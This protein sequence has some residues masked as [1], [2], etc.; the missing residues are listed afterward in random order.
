MSRLVTFLPFVCLA[1]AAVAQTIT[2]APAGFETA[3]GTTSVLYPFSGTL[4]PAGS[5]RYQEVHTSLRTTPL[6]NIVA[7]NFRRDEGTTTTT[8]AVARTANIE[9]VL[10]LGDIER[11]T[12][13][14]AGNILA[15][16]TVAFVRKPVNLADWT[17]PGNGTTP[18]PWTNRLPL[19]VPFSYPGTQDLVWE[20]SYDSMTPTGT[21]NSDRATASG[22]LWNSTSGTNIGTGCVATGRTA[23]FT[24]TTTLFHHVGSKILR[25]QYYVANGPTSQPVVMHVAGQNSNIVTPLLCGTLIAMPTISIPMGVTSAT[26]GTSTL[27]FLS[28]PF[29]NS[30]L[31]FPIFM[32]SAAIDPGLG[33]GVLPVALSQG[34]QCTWPAVTATGGTTAYIYNADLT[35]TFGSGPFT[36]GSVILG[37]EN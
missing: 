33:G 26:G 7:V 15:S 4:A 18:M 34:E 31:N 22:S 23:A 3:R 10:G 13:D 25:L 16:R 35:Q 37:L 17:A 32:Q 5:F 28:F 6:N 30:F 2:T 14:F 36:A 1:G 8:T 19:D 12:P 9:F 29:A 21:Y 11:F 24:L 20:V 27:N